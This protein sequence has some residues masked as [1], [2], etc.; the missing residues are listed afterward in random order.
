M[1]STREL[2]LN[3]NR[4]SNITPKSI[5][6]SEPKTH[7]NVT[8]KNLS[9]PKKLLNR[10]GMNDYIKLAHI[11]PLIKSPNFS[12]VN[13]G[14]YSMI[15]RQIEGLKPGEIDLLVRDE[16]TKKI[17][18]NIKK[19]YMRIEKIKNDT[20]L[21]LQSKLEEPLQLDDLKNKRRNNKSQRHAINNLSGSK[22]IKKMNKLSKNPFKI[23]SN[24]KSNESLLLRSKLID[25]IELDRS[26]LLSGKMDIL[27]TKPTEILPEINLVRY[28][29]E[30]S[31][32]LLLNIFVC[33]RKS[34]RE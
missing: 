1:P 18:Q 33:R 16:K 21:R 17:H 25:R 14:N 5:L 3:L 27:W 8:S 20:F 13:E 31:K 11:S 15:S 34:E 32:L 23:K 28:K 26:I 30:V 10:S 7:K 6:M 9:L 4:V 29:I 22:V 12:G 2:K 24:K 19:R